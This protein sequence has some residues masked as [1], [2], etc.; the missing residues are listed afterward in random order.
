VTRVVVL[1]SD[2]TA[3]GHY[4]M[5][6]PADVVAKARP[7]WTVEVYRP[8]DV[9]FGTG[10]DGSLWQVQG[11]PDP[12]SIDLLVVQR[13][14]TRAQFEFVAWMRQHAAVVMDADDALWTIDPDNVA[15]KHWNEGPSHWKWLDAA[16]RHADIVTVTTPDLARRYGAHGRV[17]VLPNC[18]PAAVE[19]TLESVRADLD[20]TTTVGWAG[21]TGTHPHDLEVVGD[22]VGRLVGDTG[23][24]V[25]VIGAGLTPWGVPVETVAPQ[26]LG[27][28]YFTALTSLDVGLVPL[29]PTKFNR[30]KSYLKALEYAAAGV[31]VVA[32]DTPMHRELSRS[33]PLSLAGNWYD[34]MEA[35]VQHPDLR[36]E[37]VAVARES[38]FLLHTYEANAERWVAAWERAMNRHAR[39]RA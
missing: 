31:A 12:T 8:S 32:S 10:A 38:V 13:V 37:R 28:P 39:M 22:D 14:A 21:F 20:Q 16:A 33:V 19:E 35:L 34:Q 30:A 9:M 5:K 7:D 3:C 17:E 27:L 15:W 18:I 23:C 24:R 2:E 29:A 6:W 26:P 11:I 4:R 25:R 36:A 1:P